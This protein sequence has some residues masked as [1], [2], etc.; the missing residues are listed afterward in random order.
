MSDNYRGPVPNGHPQFYS[1]HA[2]QFQPPQY[3]YPQPPI[4]PQLLQ[5]PPQPTHYMQQPQQQQPP[6]QQPQGQQQSQ[7]VIA[8]TSQA[9]SSNT[10]SP[11][12]IVANRTDDWSES[13][14]KLAKAAELKKHG[15]TLQ[16][17]T[18]RIVAYNMTLQK[19][20][21]SMGGI[22][23]QKESLEGQRTQLLN[24]LRALQVDLEELK[25]LRE[26][27]EIRN[28]MKE[29]TDGEYAEAKAAV[30][31][32]RRELDLDP[33]PS[34]EQ[35]LEEKRM[36]YKEYVTLNTGAKMPTVGLG[37]WK[38]KPGEVEHAVGYALKEAGYKHVDTAAAYRNEPE[39]GKGIKASGVSRESIFLTTK[40][41]NP[42]H[43]EEEAA[44]FSS[45]KNLDTPYLDL[46]KPDFSKDW[47]DTWKAMEKVYQEHPNK[48]KAIG[49]SNF[50][51]EF[52]T[53]L[54]KEATI[55]PAVNQIELHE[56]GIVVTAYSPLGSDNSPLLTNDVVVAI[57]KRHDV[58]PANILISLWANVDN[59]TV[60][61]KSVSNTRIK[62]NS[63][64]I[65]LSDEESAE[66]LRI[67]E[68]RRYRACGPEW[69]GHG[70]LGFEDRK[71]P[72]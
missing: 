65:S 6:Q 21:R 34:L 51:V 49:V 41:N 47:L 37:T 61:P 20:E 10:E 67:A 29:M 25:I 68:T 36:P 52:L 35:K 18:S 14:V 46:L 42:D 58:H 43:G 2:Q 16:M 23:K 26:C 28:Q 7:P 48:V 38:S 15:L 55:V 63:N 9:S 39:V 17:H 69:T 8:S 66:L 27:D 30:D 13:L 57:A 45:L 1:P 22:R 40:L 59:T 32:L 5:Q 12:G 60:I 19:K 62:N 70:H 71:I 64:I 53:R 50:S 11:R 31:R 54:L 72:K 24:R 3:Y 44:L 56:N 4:T 33:A